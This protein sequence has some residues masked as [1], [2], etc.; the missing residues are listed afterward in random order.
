MRLL[1]NVTMPHEPF[2]TAVRDGSVSEENGPHSERDRAEA[3]YFTERNGAQGGN[4]DL[5]PRRSIEDPLRSEP[6]FLG[7]NA[8]VE[9]RIVMTPEDL[10]KA[11]SGCRKKWRR[12]LENPAER[13]AAANAKRDCGFS[14]AAPVFFHRARRRTTRG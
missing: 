4:P 13:A 3:V 1:M 11:G 8:D 2:N 5:R 10:K 12:P 14:P 7:F 9:F 6:W